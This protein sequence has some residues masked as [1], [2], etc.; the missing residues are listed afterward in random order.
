MNKQKLIQYKNWERDISL[1]QL[2]QAHRRL[3]REIRIE[4]GGKKITIDMDR[5]LL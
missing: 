1:R 4:N 2:T 3:Q 5:V